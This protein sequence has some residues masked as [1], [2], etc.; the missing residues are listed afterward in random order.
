VNRPVGAGV[1]VGRWDRDLA[2]C[3]DRSALRP[4]PGGRADIPEGDDG[5]GDHPGTR[6][7]IHAAANGKE[8]APHQGARALAR[9]AV[10]HELAARHAAASLG[11]RAASPRPSV[12]P[13]LD[14]AAGHA[15]PDLIAHAA[16]HQHRALGEPGAEPG[17]PAEV[18]GE[19]YGAVGRASDLAHL[20]ERQLAPAAYDHGTPDQLGRRERRP[21]TREHRREIGGRCRGRHPGD[22]TAHAAGPAMIFRR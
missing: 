8:A 1:A 16:V 20:A 14:A 9:R 18:A 2:E 5:A 22:Q 10:Y 12:A 17:D 13:D 4:E 11:S 19:A 6:V 21:G 3:H 15:E 7:V